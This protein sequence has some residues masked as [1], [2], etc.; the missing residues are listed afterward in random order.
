MRIGVHSDRAYAETTDAITVT[1]E[2]IYLE[3]QSEPDE[4]HFVWAYHVRIE[5]HGQ[6]T[7]QLLTRHWRITDSM[8]KMHE[9][10]GDGVVGEQPV[11][12]PG[13]AF[14]Y[15]SGTPLSTPS[16]IMDGSY[17][18]ETDSGERFDV[19][20]PAFSLDCPHHRAQVH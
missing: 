8:G 2:P 4:N 17:Q 3:E 19:K 16:G 10:R 14:E 7:V 13:G 9:V 1:V 12:A 6:K 5:N 15:T 18:M 11:L 20:I